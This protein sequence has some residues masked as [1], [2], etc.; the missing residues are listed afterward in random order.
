L[1]NPVPAADPT[2]ITDEADNC[3][4]IPTVTHLSDVSDG[5]ACPEI[6]TRTYQIED[7]C[8]NITLVT[9]LIT[10]ADGIFPT[11]SNPAPLVVECMADVPAPNPA[12][13]TDEADNGPVPSVTWESDTP[14]GSCPIVVDRVYRVTDNCGNFIFVTQTIT[15]IPSTNPVVPANGASTVNCLVDAQVQPV[16]PVVTDVCGNNIVPV[17]TVPTN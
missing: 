7:A 12:V 1:G 2:L 6:I 10:I 8:G 15:V 16:A 11:A 3:G 14:A 13:V 17:V 9:Q 4:T 5:G